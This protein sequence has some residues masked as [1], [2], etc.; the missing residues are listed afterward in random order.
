MSGSGSVVFAEPCARNSIS[1]PAGDVMMADGG[2]LVV[3]NGV[4]FCC[5]SLT[6]GGV[7]KHGGW[8]TAQ[9]LPGVIEGTGRVRVGFPGLCVSFR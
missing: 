2:K 6:V 9:R 1:V 7:S 8:Y 4:T 5:R 3:S